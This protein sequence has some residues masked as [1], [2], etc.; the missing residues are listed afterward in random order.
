MR[1]IDVGLSGT[2]AIALGCA[3]ELGR[4]SALGPFGGPSDAGIVSVAVER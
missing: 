1:E 4:D 3:S 2:P